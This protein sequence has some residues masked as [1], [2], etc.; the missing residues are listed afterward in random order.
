MTRADAAR[1]LGL[2]KS[3][4]TRWTKKHPALL[5]DDGL[6]DLR[7]LQRHREA[8]VN[9][10]LKTWRDAQ[11]LDAMPLPRIRGGSI[12]DHRAR[13]EGAKAINAE[14]DVAKRLNQTVI[15]ADVETAIVDAF[16]VLKSQATSLAQDRAEALARIDDPRA[17]ERALEDL[18]RE[19]LEKGADDLS[20]HE[21]PGQT[22]DST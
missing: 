5:G 19:L 16:E 17:M 22:A 6:V 8:M 20:R 12:N 14:M 10:A 18:L 4:V 11:P 1:A 7:E 21:R 13:G 15:R 9:P 2:D 3:T